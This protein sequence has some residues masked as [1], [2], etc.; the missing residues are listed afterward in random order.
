MDPRLEEKLAA[1]DTA[2]EAYMLALRELSDYLA[3]EAKASTERAE[4]WAHVRRCQV[5]EADFEKGAVTFALPAGHA[6]G[7]CVDVAVYEHDGR[8]SLTEARMP[9]KDG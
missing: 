1:V 5:I 6:I 8:P 3:A 7:A 4:R 2:R 9:G